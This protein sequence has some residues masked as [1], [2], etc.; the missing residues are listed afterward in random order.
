MRKN[1]ETTEPGDTFRQVFESAPDAMVVVDQ[2]GKIVLV[3]EQAE[4][5]FGYSRGELL[6][7]P[8]E[9]LVPER[10]RGE[11]AHHRVA[12]TSHPRVRPMGS[13]LDLYGRRKDGSEFPAEISLSPLET[14]EG[15]LIS[16]AIRDITER[17]KAEQALRESE[18]KYRVVAESA[19]D[20]IITIDE[21]SRITY[22]NPATEKVF[23]Y[24][25]DKLLGQPLT[26]L[27]P[28]PLRSRHTAAIAKFID[29]GQ[30]SISWEGLELTGLH[31]SGR[32]IPIEISFGAIRQEDGKYL[33][34][35]IVRDIS[36]RKQ[37]EKALQEQTA[38]VRL[39]QKIAVAANEASVVDKAIQVCLD[40][41]CTLTKWPVG[42]AYTLAADGTG[43]LVTTGL[44]HLDH[45]NRFETFRNVTEVTRF[46]LG[47]GLPG[48]VLASGR[49]AWIIDVTKDSNFPRATF[50]K[51]IGVKAGF[52][53]PVLVGT[54]VVAVLEFF[55]AA[56]IEPDEPL[57]EV[58]AH[59]GTQLGRV[60]ERTQAKTALQ[61]AKDDLEIRV[62]ERTAELSVANENLRREIA[63]RTR[64]EA[65]L[66][67]AEEK[68]RSIFEHAVEGIFQTTPEGRYISA[69]LALARIYGY[70][71]P[72]ELVENLTDIGP[73][74]YLEPTRRADFIRLLQEQSAVLGL[75]SQVY[76]RDGRAIWI[77]ESARAV[78]DA[79]G[80]V[81]YYEGT[82]QDITDRKRAEEALRESEERLARILESAMDAVV[83]IDTRHQIRLFNR[84]A[85]A[86]FRCPASQAI[87]KSVGQFLSAPLRRVL[88]E[89]VTALEQGDKAKPY[90]WIPDG[91]TA[92]RTDGHEFPIEGTISQMEA[93]GQ[94]FYTV[95]LRDIN[96][97]KQAEAE[98][99]KLQ[100]ENVYL[101][102]EIKTVRNFEEIVGTS[103][104]IKQVLRKVE[105][106]AATGATV[107]LTGETGTGKE[108][109]AR[110]VHNLSRRKDRPLIKVNCAALPAGLIESELFGHERGAF[111]GAVSRKIGRFQLADGGTIFLDEIGDIPPEV[112]VKLLR[113]LQEKEFER[114][115]GTET[116]ATD[117]RVIAGTNQNLEALREAGRFREDLF[118][119][120]NVYPISLPPLRERKEDLIPLA[121]HFLQKFGRELRKEVTSL[122]PEAKELITSY[123]WPGNVR[124]LE[125]VMERAVILCR[126]TVVTAQELSLSLRERPRRQPES[127]EALSLPPGGINLLDTEK[128]LILK[129]L[130]Q[131]K[132]NK[133]KT[134]KLL[135]LS[136]TQLRT[137]M[138]KHGLEP[139]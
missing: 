22:G 64:A 53:F 135:G 88:T 18:E 84:A 36:E 104:A 128:Q 56:A 72:E 74:L 32:E 61:Q 129:A 66:R 76:R 136:R 33:F 127:G 92:L 125:N 50:A 9:I 114:L 98:L 119:R 70:E 12:Y 55:S 105:Q 17:K 49:P 29:T 54:E 34:T 108:L 111:T 79:S 133:S 31:C 107:L 115:G 77:S 101:Q 37:A 25:A 40:E 1:T 120:L 13:G 91:L 97:R 45:P 35:G 58:M 5:L 75:E 20:A 99:N 30:Q 86:V 23:G 139:G 67:Q 47:V 116:I 137:R 15:V 51:D 42:H 59:I 8:A 46:A 65:A 39:L 60:I 117:V 41:V 21:H 71:S 94:K 89:H 57:L 132:Y 2:E 48:R 11:H 138:K 43:E 73:Q 102:E 113:V 124:E 87:G 24:A 52:G 81:L 123:H 106:V 68:Y 80:A 103:P 126:G 93:A 69:N 26:L 38:Y 100:L 4:R 109:I 85:E 3:N 44:W 112:Q 121:R 82:V 122:S 78:R 10:L 118:Y 63:E 110:A 62:D 27:M 83:T 134:S 130:E 14:A 16:T 95:I 19:T 7:Q 6:G 90:R 131:A 28:E 96:E